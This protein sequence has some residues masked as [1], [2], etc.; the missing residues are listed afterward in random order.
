M[1]EPEYVR[2]ERRM[3]E[4]RAVLVPDYTLG[5]VTVTLDGDEWNW[6]HNAP[7]V[8]GT[9]S[10]C[11]AVVVMAAANRRSMRSLALTIAYSF[12]PK[13]GHRQDYQALLA[14]EGKDS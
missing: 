10:Q 12:C 4:M 2:I 11:G 6:D 14:D 1:T 5:T 9:C 7:Y 8:R 13:R 3:T